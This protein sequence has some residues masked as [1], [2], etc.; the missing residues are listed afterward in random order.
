MPST[1]AASASLRAVASLLKRAGVRYAVLG[2]EERCTGDPARRLGEEGLFQE[3]AR[4]NITTLGKYGVRKILTQC[5]HCFNTLKN[6]YGTLGGRYEV[7]HHSEFIRQLIVEGRLKLTDS[8]GA[9][10]VTYHDSCY[11]GRHN[12]VYA[13]PREAL[14]SAPGYSYGKSRAAAT[15]GSVAA[16]AAPICGSISAL[17][18]R[19]TESVSTRPST[20][21]P[22]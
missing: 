18:R 9:Q 10:A 5:P 21:G 11:L 17:A 7:M 20:R 3:L 22:R 19:S 1:S 12:D 14:A 8:A 16:P 4:E 2:P 6:E 13:A 15:R